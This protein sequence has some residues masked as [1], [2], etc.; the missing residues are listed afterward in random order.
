MTHSN[1]WFPILWLIGICLA[2]IVGWL[3]TRGTKPLDWPE[4]NKPRS[5]H[6]KFTNRPPE[7]LLP[8]QEGPS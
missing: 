7:P 8:E 6:G 3:M 4:M 1:N 5:D 2:P